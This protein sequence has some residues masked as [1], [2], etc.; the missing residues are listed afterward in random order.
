MVVA[1]AS[2]SKAEPTS[3]KTKENQTS[4]ARKAS[5]PT[6]DKA[7]EVVAKVVAKV[8]AGVA[9]EDADIIVAGDLAAEVAE[10]VGTN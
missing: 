3:Q 8:E 7:A 5:P 6:P 1:R 10:A 2:P 4:I 9:A